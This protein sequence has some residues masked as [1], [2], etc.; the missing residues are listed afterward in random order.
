MPC[1][2]G[3]LCVPGALRADRA[4]DRRDTAGN[5]CDGGDTPSIGSE[6]RASSDYCEARMNGTACPRTQRHAHAVCS[7]GVVG[8][9]NADVV[10]QA[11]SKSGARATASWREGPKLSL[12][13][14][15]V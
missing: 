1:A 5:E 12:S 11:A 7:V 10:A 2:T 9:F 4:V 15:S 8:A 3:F 6:A 14:L 13:R